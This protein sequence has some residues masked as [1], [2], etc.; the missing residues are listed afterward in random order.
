MR[1]ARFLWTGIVSAIAVA[2][3]TLVGMFLLL[4]VGLGDKNPNSTLAKM[5]FFAS[6]GLIVYPACWYVI[7][8]RQQDY[9]F[10]QTL[11]LVGVTFG[12]VSAIIAQIMIVFCV[13]SLIVFP[14]WRINPLFLILSPLGFVIWFAF[15]LV[16]LA[17]PYALVAPPMAFFQRYCLSKCF[18]ISGSPA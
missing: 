16:L 4:F 6:P 7:I 1:S 8:F 2:A 11:M 13:V 12:V 9:S 10:R 5:V 3:L 15:G 17:I 18:G 14:V